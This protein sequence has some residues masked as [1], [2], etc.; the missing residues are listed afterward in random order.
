T[1]ISASDRNLIFHYNNQDIV[2]LPNGIDKSYFVPQ[3][4]A[5]NFELLFTGNMSYPPNVQSA[6]YLVR[7]IMP[8]VWKELP[9]CR[10]LISGA[11]PVSSVKSLASD[12][13]TVRPWIDDIRTSYAESQVFIA[14]M[15][16]GSGM[17]NKLLEAMS[18]KLPCITSELAN[19]ALGA[20]NGEAI[21]VGRN[22]REYADFILELLKNPERARDVAEK[23]Y[24]FVTQTF[25]WSKSNE[26]ILHLIQEKNARVEK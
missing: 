7:K 13:V 15:L 17:Q 1:V 11:N 24:S 23:G 22:E 25:D 8:L 18:M 20:D 12:L 21:L 19:R 4:K 26:Q 6:V 5:T 9:D 3:Q 2:I 10:L 14:P 16:I